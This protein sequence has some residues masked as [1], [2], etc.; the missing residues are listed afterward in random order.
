[1]K[2]MNLNLGRIGKMLLP[3]FFLMGLFLLNA[4]TVQA[5]SAEEYVVKVKQ[6]VNNLPKVNSEKTL[7]S[8]NL[9]EEL[10][11]PALA[12][13]LLIGLEAEFGR[14]IIVGITRNGFEAKESVE[15]TYELLG[16]EIPAEYLDPIK[17]IYVD[18]LN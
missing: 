11:N 2:K 14:V 7:T 5:Q 1:M 3:V 4:N 10:N 18:L 17:E 13:D 12:S 9:K 15:R 8:K 16:R 6:H